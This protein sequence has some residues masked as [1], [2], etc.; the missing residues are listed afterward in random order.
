MSACPRCCSSCGNQRQAGR[1]AQVSSLARLR[2]SSP[3]V[4]R[5]MAPKAKQPHP[6]TVALEMED[7]AAPARKRDRT[8]GG[9]DAEAKRGDPRPALALETNGGTTPT[10]RVASERE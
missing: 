7:E 2:N 8:D 10:G 3:P 1:A 5:T 6:D 4:C 9:P